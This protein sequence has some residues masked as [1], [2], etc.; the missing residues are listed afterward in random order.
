M[1]LLGDIGNTETKICLVSLNN[2]IIKKIIF[3][4]KNITN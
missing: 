3:S 4:S 1:L 2:K